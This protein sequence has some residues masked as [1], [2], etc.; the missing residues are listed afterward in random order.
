MEL[1]RKQAYA[2]IKLLDKTTTEIGYGGG[3]GGGKSYLGCIWIILQALKYPK[4]AWLIGR[5]ELTNL[6][7]TTLI[8]FF[9]VIEEM[10]INTQ[11]EVHMNSLTNIITFNNKS[12]IFLMD[13]SPQPS[14]PLYTRFG[15]LELT[16]A[17]IDESNE[18]DIQAIEIIKTRIGRAKNKEYNLTPKILE[19]FNPAKNHVYSRYYKPYRDKKMP[20]HR[21]FI[22][23]LAPDNP[24]L[25]ESYINQLRNADKITRERLLNGNFEYDD[26]PTKIF[27]YE[28][29][30]DMFTNEPKGNEDRY[31]I[32][33]VAGRGR[34]KTVLTCWTGF[35]VN[36][37]IMMDNISSEE[38]DRFLITNQVPRSRC[39][40]DEDGVG[41]GLV[42]DTTGVK[43]FINNSKPIRNK[44]ETIKKYE[45][46][47]NLKAQC[48]FLLSNY[49]KKRMIGIYRDIQEDI[50]EMIIQDLEQIKQKN[51]GNDQPLS[52]ISKDEIKQTIGRSTD[53][54]DTFMM[55]MWFELMPKLGPLTI[56]GA[57]R[58]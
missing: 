54:G 36:K 5:R 45:N 52:I 23:A 6:K 19:T 51:P 34:D 9:R 4:T 21:V 26:D 58:R 33:D 43:G 14:D 1:T 42:K 39:L 50:K 40:V 56:V 29:I 8:S 44:F 28:S 47:S 15:S 49:V 55:R 46:Y 53:I 48:W 18:N 57:G 37:I 12:I 38:L 17:F 10:R 22:P 35:M 7:K 3:A 20:K 25:S 30:I 2:L 32:V 31:V 13:M 11:T 24:H 27:D 16:G 41:F